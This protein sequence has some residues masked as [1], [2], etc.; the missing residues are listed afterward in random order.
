MVHKNNEDKIKTTISKIQLEK[1]QR[2]PDETAKR[3]EL[4]LRQQFELC[5]DSIDLH[6]TEDVGQTRLFCEISLDLRLDCWRGWFRS[7]CRTARM[8]DNE[9]ECVDL[10]AGPEPPARAI[11]FATAAQAHQRIEAHAHQRIDIDRVSLAESVAP[12]LAPCERSGNV[13]EPGR[14]VRLQATPR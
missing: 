14:Q 6:L 2:P 9:V 13:D 10:T 11:D 4:W 5:R 12:K 1:M 3:V 7:L 8:Q